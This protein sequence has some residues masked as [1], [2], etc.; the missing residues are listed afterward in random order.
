MEN[1]SPEARYKVVINDEE[2]YALWPLALPNPAGWRE[3][4][5]SGTKDECLDYVKETWT[6]MTPRSLRQA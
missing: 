5:M 6:D 3:A 2:Q 1:Q 4:G